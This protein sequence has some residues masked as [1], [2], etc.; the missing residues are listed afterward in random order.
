MRVALVG[1]YPFETGKISGGPQ[2][3]SVY[4]LEG[5][6]Q[7][8]GL[9][10]HLISAHKQLSQATRFEREKVTFH[11]LPHP[12]C[13]FEL[14]YPVLRRT[15][16]QILRSLAPDLVHT[17]SGDMY[18]SAC[19]GTGYPT[20]ATV[21]S[22]PGSEVRFAPNRLTRLRLALHEQLAHRV[23]LPNI[24]HIICI[25]E[26]IRN[27]LAGGTSATLYPIENPVADSFFALPTHQSVGG[28]ILFVGYLHR[29]KRPDLALKALALARTQ[30]Q[31]LHLHLAGQSVDP[32]LMT[33][34]NNFIG[35][36]NLAAH[37]SFL[38]HLPEGRLL[39][40]YQQAS[41]LLLTSEMETS[42]MAIEQAMAAGKAVVATAVGGVPYLVENGRTGLTV[43][44]DCPEL[45]AAALVKLDKE[46]AVCSQLGQA[47]RAEARIRFQASAVAQKTYQVYRQILAG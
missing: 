39:E 32:A 20:V 13:P 3:V 44:P 8:E 47:G 27:G 36:N 34:L 16:R 45:L 5:L 41:I 23:F 24:R 17:L 33:A 9:E 2:A 10:L 12:R 26:Y 42:P 29:R 21:H 1:H 38:G 4:L 40:A 31:Q 30:A 7:I 14:A 46:P 43:P 11:F 18:G 35:Q 22:I 19:I 6:K 28:R 15:I 25:S 37:V